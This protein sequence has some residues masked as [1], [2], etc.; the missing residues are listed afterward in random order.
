MKKIQ[1]TVRTTGRIPPYTVNTV[2]QQV[3]DR[4]RTARYRQDNR[5]DT[6][7]TTS[8]IQTRQQEGHR[9]GNSPNTDRKACRIQTE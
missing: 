4:G 9:Q 1:D 5:Q 2:E 3:Q 6:D 8:R 7:S